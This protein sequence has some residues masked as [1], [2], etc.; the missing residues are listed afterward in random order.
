MGNS[1][2]LCSA[3]ER[4]ASITDLESESS[5]STT[6]S[7]SLDRAATIPAPNDKPVFH[8]INQLQL[9]PEEGPSE[10]VLS[11]DSE[12][13]E[14]PPGE[15]TELGDASLSLEE[16]LLEEEKRLELRKIGVNWNSFVKIKKKNY[17]EDY[18][19]QK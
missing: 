18:I 9:H 10:I 12:P 4:N 3:F 1:N 7:P 13:L 11:E 6:P 2:S 14:A 19:F 16:I 8:K 17:L 15:G 5:L